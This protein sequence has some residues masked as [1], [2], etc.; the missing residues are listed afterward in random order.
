MFRQNFLAR[1]NRFRMTKKAAGKTI[2]EYP[3]TKARSNRLRAVLMRFVVWVN[4]Y[5]KQAC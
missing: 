3:K 1:F 5:I 4:K 2:C